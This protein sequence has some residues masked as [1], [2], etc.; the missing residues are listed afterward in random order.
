[1]LAD[2]VAWWKEGRTAG[3]NEIIVFAH[4]ARGFDDILLVVGDHLNMLK[5]YTERE[6]ELGHIGGVCCKRLTEEC[7]RTRGGLAVDGL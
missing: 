6:A 3:N 7:E 1:M 5:V 2:L 4:S